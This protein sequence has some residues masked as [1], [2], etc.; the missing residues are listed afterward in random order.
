MDAVYIQKPP[1]LITKKKK[2][3]TICA[4]SDIYLLGPHLL[5]SPKRI[6]RLLG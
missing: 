4:L 1:L 6:S 3:M 2:S 5:G